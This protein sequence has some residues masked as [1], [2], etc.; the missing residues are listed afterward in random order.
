MSTDKPLDYQPSLFRYRISQYALFARLLLGGSLAASERRLHEARWGD[1]E[2]CGLS[3]QDAGLRFLDLGNGSMRP[4]FMLLRREGFEVTGV[5]LVNGHG[6]SV[7]QA[8]YGIARMFLAASFGS[9]TLA[10]ETEKLLAARAEALP[11][12]ASSIDC[13][14]SVAAMEHFLEPEKVI[15]EVARVLRPGGVFWCYV[16][17]FAG[18][19]GGHTFYGGCEPTTV[20]PDGETPWEHLRTPQWNRSPVPLNRWRRDRYL[21]AMRRHFNVTHHYCMMREG[22]E[23]LTPEIQRALPD[24]DRDE[25]LS[26]GY[27]FVGVK[28]VSLSLSFFTFATHSWVILSAFSVA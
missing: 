3:R 24:Y 20:L 15:E 12:S 5:D 1:L 16:H 6:W 17:L 9:M 28:L 18:L 2:R 11:I 25:L 19:S 13:V 22:E 4:Q 14:T 8:I 10:C 7:A 26:S 23:L 21:E 27:V